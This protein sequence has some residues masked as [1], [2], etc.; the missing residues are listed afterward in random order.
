M[1]S[2][3][4]SQ[5]FKPQFTF[6]S[7][8]NKQEAQTIFPLSKAKPPLFSQELPQLG[9]RFSPF[10]SQ[11]PPRL[12]SRSKHNSHR[13]LCNTTQLHRSHNSDHLAD[14]HEDT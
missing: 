12:E 10:I 8:D 14:G 9:H 5:S 7:K 1:S 2:Q 6:T 11:K 13:I 4:P 3:N